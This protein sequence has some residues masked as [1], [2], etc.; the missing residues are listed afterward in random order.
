MRP[1]ELE[2]DTTRRARPPRA[3]RAGAP[4]QHAFNWRSLTIVQPPTHAVASAA[5][6][7]TVSAPGGIDGCV[8]KIAPPTTAAEPHSG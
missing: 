4:A 7:A 1:Q 5:S 2:P 8:A 3:R 6:T